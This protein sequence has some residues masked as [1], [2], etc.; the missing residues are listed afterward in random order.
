MDLTREEL[1]DLIGIFQKTHA[2]VTEQIEDMQKKNQELQEE[3]EVL[4]TY[5]RNVK[6]HY[7]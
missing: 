4:V 2:D 6:A 5:V 7:G 1:I 3:N